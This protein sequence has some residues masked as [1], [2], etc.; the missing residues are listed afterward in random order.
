MAIWTKQGFCKAFFNVWAN[1]NSGFN[2][3]FS[4]VFVGMII[5]RLLLENGGKDIFARYFGKM[6]QYLH[7]WLTSCLAKSLKTP[8][9][10]KT[11]QSWKESR[12][13]EKR[14][15]M[16]QKAFFSHFYKQHLQKACLLLILK[17]TFLWQICMLGPIKR[18]RGRKHATNFTF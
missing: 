12:K 2:V 8:F 9:V 10:K 7:K 6:C 4:F 17:V 18:C 3:Y 15:K 16:R 5:W 11:E 13:A 1:R 14:E